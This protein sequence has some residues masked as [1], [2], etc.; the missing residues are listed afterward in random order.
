[1]RWTRSSCRRL[2]KVPQ[3]KEQ[4]ARSGHDEGW[5]WRFLGDLLV[6][7]GASGRIEHP[8]LFFTS[9]RLQD[10]YIVLCT[11]GA[12][13][14]RLRH[15][16]RPGTS[17]APRIRPHQNSRLACRLRVW[18]TVP[19]SHTGWHGDGI[20]RPARRSSVV[21]ETSPVLACITIGIPPTARTTSKTISS[22]PVSRSQSTH[23]YSQL[24]TLHN[25][26][27]DPRSPALPRSC[28]GS[29]PYALLLPLEGSICW[30]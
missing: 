6:P 24:S 27:K 23:H 18:T 28:N 4:A 30:T 20:Y 13:N 17:W 12:L 14:N 22:S 3:S 26:P 21:G 16:A 19:G 7:R 5:R 15:P 2:P 25:Q 11:P 29:S 9:R 8:T 1:M 10:I